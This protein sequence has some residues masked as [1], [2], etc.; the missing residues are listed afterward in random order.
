LDTTGALDLTFNVG[1]GA[2]SWVSNI[3]LQPDG[4]I[5]IGGGFTT[6]NGTARN[7]IARLNADGTLDSSFNPGA[8]ANSTV[9]SIA[10]QPDGKILIGGQFTT[11]YDTNRNGVARLNSDGTLD[12]SFNPG[13]G[14]NGTVTS[15][16]LQPDGMI[17]IGGNFTTYNGTARNRIARLKADGTLDTIFNPG[18]G[19]NFDINTT[20]IQPDGMIVIGGNFTS[21]NG[22]TR[23]YLARLIGSVLSVN[24]N[25]LPLPAGSITGTA[26]VCQGQSAESYTVP[27]ITNATGYTWTLPAGA[28]IVSGS[29]TN[30]I[31]VNFSGT[32]S[33]GAIT[34]QGSNSC[35]SGAV[36]AGY[37]VTVNNTVTWY[38]DADGDG[39]N[40]TG[41][42]T[43]QVA[44]SDPGSAWIS[45]T[46]G[47]DCN[48][49]NAAVFSIAA[50]VCGDGLDN[51]CDGAVDEACT[52]VF[53]NDFAL[54]ATNFS[55]NVNQN[56]PGCDPYNAT[57]AGATDS[58]ESVYNGLDRW[59]KFIA[60]STAVT[61]TVSSTTQ[62]DAIGLYT[63][64]GASFNLLDFENASSGNADMERLNFY[65]L[66]PGNEYYIAV[67]GDNCGPFT[68]CIQHLLRSWCAYT[69]PAS[70]FQ[71]CSSLKCVFRGNANSNVS[72]TFHFTETGGTELAPFETT[73]ASTSST[74][75]PLNTGALALQYGGIYNVRVDALYNLSNSA[76]VPQPVV[77]QGLVT[78]P[79]CTGVTLA[80]HPLLEVKA[81]QR[82][83]ASIFRGTYLNGARVGGA[84]PIC[85][86]LN[87]SF[88]FQQVASCIDGTTVN[89]PTTYTNG[90]SSPYIQ[91]GVLPIGANA[92]AWD[93]R[94]K[95]NFSYGSGVYG[96]TQRIRVNGSS[97]AGELIY[98][99][100]ALR[101]FEEIESNIIYP[102]PGN[103]EFV[104]IIMRDAQPGSKH[105]RVLDEAGRSVTQ[106]FY[107]VEDAGTIML[108]FDEKLSAGVYIIE[109]SSASSVTTHRLVVQ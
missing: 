35:G 93:V 36:S 106:R 15:I 38:L 97:A 37:A 87:Y 31:T 60:Q 89:F 1:T 16:A 32:A 49:S 4:K 82:C 58:P 54:G 90:S 5:I 68:M 44:C 62:D 46:L 84:S 63:K 83:P 101:A 26:T 109:L 52:Q 56:Y 91:L 80:T 103:G 24:V 99:E 18:I 39:Y 108:E 73:S 2:S 79:N 20:T 3:V 100:D 25:P 47:N 40:A 66:V 6:Y 30:S 92:G 43:T 17:I 48:D 74:Y 75:M 19:A 50:E 23:N 67:G 28:S 85:G 77:V 7:Y 14:A 34:V 21:Y 94:I 10:L 71:L 88:E 59:Y 45:N 98:D 13:G 11:Y 64:A 41:V 22:V 105:V 12:S 95:P 33:S 27:A 57:L 8:G 104:N 65:N 107:Q 9:Y 51:D 69:Q 55:Y 96:P 76:G 72:Y 81:S 70:G 86:A 61:I 102:N 42:G 29:D 53:T 78:D